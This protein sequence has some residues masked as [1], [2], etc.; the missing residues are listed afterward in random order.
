MFDIVIGLAFIA[1]I[2]VP[3]IA[4]TVQHSDDSVDDE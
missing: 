1:M 4:A 3:A 2:V